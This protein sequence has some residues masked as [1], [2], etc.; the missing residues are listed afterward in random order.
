MRWRLNLIIGIAILGAQAA[1]VGYAHFG[2]APQGQSWLRKTVNGC[3]AEPAGCRRYVAWAPNDYLVEYRLFVTT[4][5][6]RL[7]PADARR[8]YGLLVGDP[9]DEGIWEA[10]PQRLIDTIE[11]YERDRDRDRGDHVILTYTVNGGPRHKWRWPHP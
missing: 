9:S 8:R 2:P 11:R 3:S 5:G 1:A 10:P 6:R 7:S 4:G